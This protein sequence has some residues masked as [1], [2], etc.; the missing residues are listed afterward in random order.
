MTQSVSDI[1]PVYL[2]DKRMVVSGREKIAGKIPSSR[3]L[4][5]E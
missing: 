5:G 3:S 2:N 4:A 1:D